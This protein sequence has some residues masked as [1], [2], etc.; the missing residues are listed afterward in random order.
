MEDNVLEELG[1]YFKTAHDI[2]VIEFFT[3]FYPTPE[4]PDQFLVTVYAKNDARERVEHKVKKEIE[5]LPEK[6]R[7]KIKLIVGIE[8]DLMGIR[9]NR[10]ISTVSGAW[11]YKDFD[12]DSDD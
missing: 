11:E 7:G 4:I 3:G 8:S 2:D 12:S 5:D 6:Y 1:H 10:P 9:W